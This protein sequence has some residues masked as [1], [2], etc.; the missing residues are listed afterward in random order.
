[1]EHTANYELH[2]QLALTLDALRVAEERAIAGR[3]ALET[4]HEIR[5][6]LEVLSHLTFLTHEESDHPQKVRSYMLEAAEQMTQLR[7]IAHHTLGVARQTKMPKHSNLSALAEA[8]IR[9]HQK[10]IYDK[11]IHLV[12]DLPEAVTAPVYT[13]EILQVICNLIG[14]ALDALPRAGTLSLRLRKRENE[15]HL[16]VADTGHGIDAEHATHIFTPFFTTKEDRGLG[17]GL[18]LSKRIVERHRGRISMR[19]S[20]QPGKSGTIFR[21][22]LPV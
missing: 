8:A 5:G 13:S 4:M 22:A 20:V 15:V 14:N 1:M 9:V 7:E 3:L 21:V 2:R 19:S 11:S 6:P 12:K 16:I 17:L 10:T 18:A